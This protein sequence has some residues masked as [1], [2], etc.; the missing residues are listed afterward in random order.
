MATPGQIYPLGEHG[1]EL[2][3]ITD[4]VKAVKVQ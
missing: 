3:K 4:V 1:N 2:K